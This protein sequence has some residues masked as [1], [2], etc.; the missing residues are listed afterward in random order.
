M[1]GVDA[2]F[3]ERDWEARDNLLKMLSSL[4]AMSDRCHL[5][6]LATSEFKLQRNTAT[7]FRNGSEKVRVSVVMYVF[8]RK[9]K[10]GSTAIA[11]YVGIPVGGVLSLCNI[12]YGCPKIRGF[13]RP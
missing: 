9:G 11:A 8:Y 3:E 13:C 2:L 5:R 4:C 6:L 1:D 10:K 12:L 7:C